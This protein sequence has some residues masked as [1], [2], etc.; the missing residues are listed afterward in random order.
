MLD[1]GIDIDVEEGVAVVVVVEVT[2]VTTAVE[3]AV[4][5]DDW[6]VTEDF[7]SLD[8]FGDCTMT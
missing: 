7:K 8:F 1:K 3:T 6:L 2:V 4:V 5:V